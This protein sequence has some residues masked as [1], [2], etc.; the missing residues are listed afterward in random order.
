MLNFFCIS[1][2]NNFVNLLQNKKK[3]FKKQTLLPTLLFL[4]FPQ[5]KR[6]NGYKLKS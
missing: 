2:K 5:N 6:P 1:I 3:N 4:S